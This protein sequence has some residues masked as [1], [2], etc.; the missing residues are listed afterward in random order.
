MVA[1]G[2]AIGLPLNTYGRFAPRSTLAGKHQLRTNASVVDADYR[3]ELR[4][5]LA[6]LK[7]QPY[8]LEKGERI[9]QLII[10]KIDNREL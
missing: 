3:G 2:I 7:D 1:T 8:R 10:E 5:V 9:T 6:N 4:L